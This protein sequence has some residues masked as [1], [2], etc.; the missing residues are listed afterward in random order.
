MDVSSMS[1][2]FQTLHKVLSP[3]RCYFILIVILEGVHSYPHCRAEELEA[4]G[5]EV[6]CPSS[7]TFPSTM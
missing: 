4:Q 2:V 1:V 6:I 7:Q 3:K 5:A